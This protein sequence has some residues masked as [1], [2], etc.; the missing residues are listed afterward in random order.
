M[1]LERDFARTFL[2]RI[3]GAWLVLRYAIF[4]FVEHSALKRR[5]HAATSLKDPLPQTPI[6]QTFWPTSASGLYLQKAVMF[7]D[8]KSVSSQVDATKKRFALEW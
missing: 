7:V 2:S 1:P 8:P 5:R 6:Q 4:C 3:Q